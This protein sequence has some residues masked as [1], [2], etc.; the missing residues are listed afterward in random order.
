MRKAISAHDLRDAD[1]RAAVSAAVSAARIIMG[2]CT[3]TGDE[4]PLFKIDDA[5]WTDELG[6]LWIEMDPSD[7]SD[8]CLVCGEVQES[9]GHLVT[10]LFTDGPPENTRILAAV[11]VRRSEAAAAVERIKSHFSDEWLGSG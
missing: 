1:A 6:V 5:E 7:D 11:P 4:F 9:R 3:V 2:R 8:V 10:T